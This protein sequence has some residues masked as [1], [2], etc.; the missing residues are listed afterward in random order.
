MTIQF[1][2]PP[3]A[4]VEVLRA[5]GARRA[6]FWYDADRKA[7]LPSHPALDALANELAG[8]RR[9]FAEHEAIFLEVGA[10]TGALYGAFL[11]RTIRG[12][13]AG[14][15]RHWPYASLR[16]F[17]SDGLR[18]ARSMGRKN[19]L[20]GLWWGGGKG[21]IARQA[22]ER[23]LDPDYRDV[24]YREYGTFVTS[25]RGVYYAAEDVGTTPNDMARVFATTRFTTCIPPAVGGSGDPSP[26]TAKGVVCAI[27]GALAHLGLGSL[28]GKRVAMQGVGAVGLPM[29]EELLGAEVGQIV[30][31]DI[32]V[33]QLRAARSRLAGRPVELRQVTAEDRSILAEPC[34][35]LVPNALGGVLNPETI[36]NVRA[37]LVCGAANN[38]LLDDRRDARALAQR[39]IVFVPDFVAN[40]MG[41]VHA[42][43]EQYGCLPNDPAIE[44]HFD[45]RRPDS[46]FAVTQQVLANA[47]VEGI[48][49]TESANRLADAASLVPH[50]IWGHRGKQIIDSLVADRWAER[51]PPA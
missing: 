24:L 11:H 47:S 2:M 32:S 19:A 12:H 48:T 40:R 20:A 23:Y 42:A 8:D 46:L 7:V 34:D 51:A 31:A 36:P 44:R 18:L 5:L 10:Q 37:R 27:Q 45:S 16:D 41:I 25:L 17:L 3:A 21:V 9:D 30:A 4:F 26:A 14:G 43:N 22:E 6:C 39:D 29:L 49:P 15:I 38:Q 1:D 13:G 35:V 50:P 28:Q 33:Q